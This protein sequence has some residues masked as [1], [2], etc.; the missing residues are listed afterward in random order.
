MKLIISNWCIA[1]IKAKS[2]RKITT[3][4]FIHPSKDD[5]SYLRREE[6][7]QISPLDG[8]QYESILANNTQAQQEIKKIRRRKHRSPTPKKN[9]PNTYPSKL[10]QKNAKT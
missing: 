6:K 5:L 4:I 7:F 10:S 2:A 1:I 8:T 3:P 9:H